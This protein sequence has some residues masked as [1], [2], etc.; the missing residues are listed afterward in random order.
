MYGFE[1]GHN[2]RPFVV[3]DGIEGLHRLFRAGDRLQD[4]VRRWLRIRALAL[5]EN[6][7]GL[8]PGAPLG[9]QRVGCMCLHP[10]R[11]AF[12]EPEIIPPRHGHEIAEPLVRHLVT[13]DQ[14]EQL[15]ITLRRG[16][17]VEKKML[18]RI[19]DRTPVLHRSA[20][21]LA[22][23]RDKVELGQR[24]RNAK[25]IVVVMQ[26]LTSLFQRVRRARKI[27]S[28]DHDSYICL[29]RRP[30]NPLIVADAQKQ[31]VGRHFGCFGEL[32]PV[33]GSPLVA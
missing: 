8:E 10:A 12:V 15:P 1:H 6:V 27:T 30:V 23:R 25:V 13:N 9:M 3:S 26:E 29:V 14:E 18:L 17:R 32:A 11:E 31:Q 5:L 16:L 22:R 24:I 2:R 4:W 33:A 21:D 7:L 19:E 20:D 28:L